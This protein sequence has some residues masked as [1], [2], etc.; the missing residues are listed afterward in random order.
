M[1]DTD[2]LRDTKRDPQEAPRQKKGRGDGGEKPL[3]TVSVK[4]TE[5]A[6]KEEAKT[7]RDRRREREIPRDSR[8]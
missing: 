3:E 4:G 7:D 6:G 5:R 2:G 1:G 8:G